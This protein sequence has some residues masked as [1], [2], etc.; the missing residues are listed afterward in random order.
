MSAVQ[1]ADGTL[2][3]T[4]DQPFVAIRINTD[5]RLSSAEARQSATYI[6]EASDQLDGW[7][8]R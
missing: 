5:E 6:L 2:N 1:L 8:E 7:V 4:D 3:M